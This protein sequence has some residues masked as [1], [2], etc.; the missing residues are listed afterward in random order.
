MRAFVFKPT[1]A[2]MGRFEID[3]VEGILDGFQ[4][5]AQS[6]EVEAYD[7]IECNGRTWTILGE[8]DEWKLEEGRI[9]RQVGPPAEVIVHQP[10]SRRY[11]DGYA[12][13]KWAV[14]VARFLRGFGIVLAIL[15]AFITILVTKGNAGGVFMGLLNG[16]AAGGGIYLFGVLLGAIGHILL[17]NLDQAVHSS[18]FLSDDERA[19]IMKI[20]IE[21]EV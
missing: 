7:Y 17:A 10:A 21:D 1:N 14:K 16:L 9:D 20:Q 13:G 8:S 6:N 19:A 4:S 2:P 15:M 12:A 18:P 11:V 3:Q 5:F